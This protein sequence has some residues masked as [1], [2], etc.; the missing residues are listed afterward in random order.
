MAPQDSCPHV[1]TVI[2]K[3][4][5]PGLMPTLFWNAGEKEVIKGLDILGF[6]K[7][8]QDVEKAWVSG[9]T[10]ISQRA[11]Y[12]SLLP[13]LL[14]EY[15]RLCGIDTGEA[16]P[17]IWDEFRN[18]Q[19]RLELV[20]LAATRITDDSLGRKTGG[21]LGSDLYVEE[22]NALKAGAT[23]ELDL[24]SGGATFGTYVVPCRTVGLIGHD[25][26]DAEWEAPKITPR[27]KRMYDTRRGLL[28]YSKLVPLI[29]E[30]GSVT[31]DEITGEAALFS[32]SALDQPE[33]EDERRLLEQ[34]F[35]ERETGQDQGLYDR[36][37]A[38]VRFA[39]TSV[40]MGH[41]TS[42]IAIAAR[43]ASVTATDAP[44]TEV[45]LHWAAY[46]MH[47]RVHFALEL[48]LEALT[49]MIA[50][51][52]GATVSDVVARWT[53]DGELPPAIAER[54][55]PSFSIE[56]SEPF[57]TFQAALRADAFLDGPLDRRAR[58]NLNP[59]A[60]A[61]Y[62]LSVLTSTWQ[63]A[64]EVFS[65][66]GFPGARSGA[67]RVFP[68]LSNS[69]DM[70]IH[71]LLLMLID[72]GVVEPH[73]NTTLRKMGQGMKC[74]LRFFPDGRVLRPTGM[75]VAAGYSGD[76]LGNVMGILGD[77]GMIADEDGDRVLTQ[78]GQ[79]LLDRLGGPD[80]A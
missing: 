46:E 10:T 38:T 73:L 60:Q 55:S 32:A 61:I 11:R 23:V 41:A 30:G 43:Y 51:V 27:G 13:W 50:D 15:Y 21:L 56:W 26:I 19:R 66:E 44:P 59:S 16:R 54:F 63:Q 62:A 2:H 14:M 3:L 12:L 20:V 33:S 76:R 37:L 49:T 39:L 6:R 35:M 22:A 80:C 45:S 65:L 18:V 1:P 31:A 48:L 79:A 72:R 42:P 28:G 7:I 77:L 68:I 52:D 40:R 58:R 70:P 75:A 29:L 57:S 67:D 64:R 4:R 17:P 25:S 34:A 5:R 9:V 24:D 71:S 74:S 36:F 53:E 78:C 47:R 69:A 8:D